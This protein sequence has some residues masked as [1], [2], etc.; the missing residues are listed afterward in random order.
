MISGDFSHVEK[1]QLHMTGFYSLFYLI[2]IGRLKL[3]IRRCSNEALNH[4]KLKQ[5]HVKLFN[6]HNQ[7]Y[8]GLDSVRAA[9]IAKTK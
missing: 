4:E 3:I 5:T 1:L 2:I 8:L 9:L 7:I 6:H